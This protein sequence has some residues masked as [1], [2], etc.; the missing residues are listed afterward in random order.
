MLSN[1][2]IGERIA[3]VR[4]QKNLT[5]AQLADGVNVSRQ[6]VGLIETGQTSCTVE[7]FQEIARFIGSSLTKLLDVRIPDGYTDP[8]HD[9]IHHRLQRILEQDGD[10][11]GAITAMIDAL[12]AHV[13][14]R[15]RN[16]NGKHVSK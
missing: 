9:E 4:K 6:Y 8:R 7:K 3:A 2:H 13:G 16:G 12:A 14:L 1:L 11:P 10:I 5:Q 15:R